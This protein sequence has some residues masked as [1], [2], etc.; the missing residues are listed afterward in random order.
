[1]IRRPP[2][3]TLFPYTTLFRSKLLRRTA[4]KA[5]SRGAPLVV[6]AISMAW[7]VTLLTSWPGSLAAPT[8]SANGRAAMTAANRTTNTLR[9]ELPA[10]TARREVTSEGDRSGAKGFGGEARA[11]ALEHR[12]GRLRPSVPHIN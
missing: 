10:L 11:G 2:R 12:Y 9:I 1:M 6:L 3:S 8:G 7:T 5:A 4:R